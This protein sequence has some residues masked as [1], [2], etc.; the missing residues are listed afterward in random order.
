MPVFAS[1]R[2]T[3]KAAPKVAM[4]GQGEV[5]TYTSTISYRSCVDIVH[6]RRPRFRKKVTKICHNSEARSRNTKVGMMKHA[7]PR[8][9]LPASATVTATGSSESGWTWD[10]D[11]KVM[12]TSVLV[13]GMKI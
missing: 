10:R 9:S 8:A 6:K 11:M 2:T 13:L 7:P 12:I 5:R 4:S 1:R 3:R